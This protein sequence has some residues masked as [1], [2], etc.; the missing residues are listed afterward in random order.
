[1][2]RPGISFG[3]NILCSFL[4]HVHVI[5]HMNELYCLAFLQ[6]SESDRAERY[7]GSD[8]E[9]EEEE[10][11]EDVKGQ[12]VLVPRKDYVEYGDVPSKSDDEDEFGQTY[13]LD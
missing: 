9:E 8:E 3:L 6:F 4:A 11:E 1:M 12:V 5:K 10:E 13:G 7:K 2:L